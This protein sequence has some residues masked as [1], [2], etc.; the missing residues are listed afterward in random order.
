MA[1][2]KKSE[3]SNR[4]SD[5]SRS[6]KVKKNSRETKSF[7]CPICLDP[8]KDA[9]NNSCGEDAIVC[10]GSCNTWLHRKCAGL[11][12]EAYEAATTSSVS[13]YCPHCRLDRQE[14]EIASLKRMIQHLVEDVRSLSKRLSSSTDANAFQSSSANPSCSPSLIYSQVVKSQ[15]GS[16]PITSSQIPQPKQKSGLLGH[17]PPPPSSDKRFNIIIQGIPECPSGTSKFGRVSSDIKNAGS[18]LGEFES[19]LGSHSI[20]DCLRLGKYR[21]EGHRPRPLLTKLI[22]VADVTSALTKRGSGSGQHRIKPDLSR[23]DR[24]IESVLLKKRWELIT[25]GIPRKDIKLGHSSLFVKRSLHGRVVNG[26][27]ILQSATSTIRTPPAEFTV[28]NT[29]SLTTPS[30]SPISSK[31]DTNTHSPSLDDSA[32]SLSCPPTISPTTDSPGTS[33]PDSSPLVSD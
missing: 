12:K 9:S 17:V 23:E 16:V 31:D 32:H 4:V 26:S 5:G 29:T 20:R 22:R 25:S 3:D 6:S 33:A 14:S 13:F 7:T 21:G 30:A 10:E 1:S 19:T 15:G 18:V 27:Y 11:S 8:I 28:V 2:K 24:L